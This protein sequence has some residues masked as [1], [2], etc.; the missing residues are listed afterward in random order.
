[1]YGSAENSVW[2]KAGIYGKTVTASAVT[3]WNLFHA[4]VK[5]TGA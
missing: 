3:V 5:N 1:M 4:P 2:Q